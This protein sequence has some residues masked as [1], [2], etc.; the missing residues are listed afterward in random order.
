L[1]AIERYRETKKIMNNEI[2]RIKEDIERQ[3]KQITLAQ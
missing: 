1:R 2:I 3:E